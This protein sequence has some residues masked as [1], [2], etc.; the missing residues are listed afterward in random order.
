MANP[1]DLD[2]AAATIRRFITGKLLESG[3]TGYVIGLSGGLDSALAAALAAK[4]V[5]NHKLYGLMLPYRVSSKSS[6]EDARE[7]ASHLNIESREIEISPMLDA[8]F[9]EVSTADRV[10]I[11][12]KAARERM[13]ILFDFAQ[14]RQSLV[15]GTSNRTEFA[16]GYTTWHGDSAASI[17]PLADLYKSEV[18]E[19]A[20]MVG[21]PERIITKSPSAD[22]WPGQTDEE[23]LGITYYTL[24]KL[25][26][27]LLDDGESSV[28]RLQSE[29][30]ALTDISRVVSLVN[31]NSYKRK[32]PSIASLGRDPVPERLQLQA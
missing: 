16:L 2:K 28:D 17:N 15:L 6:L 10:R 5:G 11:G 20:R 4:A 1:I 22:L 32:M 12:N 29:G 25:L 21:L 30:F 14:A 7:L 23:E 3:L 9:A 24:D 18:L 13:S 27:R 31:R 19:I 8:Y 26:I